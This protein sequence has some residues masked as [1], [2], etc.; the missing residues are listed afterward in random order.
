[1]RLFLIH[2]L[3]APFPV[4]FFQLGGNPDN[5]L[6]MVIASFITQIKANGMASFILQ[7]VKESEHPILS[8]IST[9]TPM[10]SRIMAAVIATGTAIGLHWTYTGSLLAGGTI[11]FSYPGLQAI[12]ATIWQIAQNYLFQHAWYKMVFDPSASPITAAKTSTQP[13][14]AGLQ[15]HG[16]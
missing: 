6:L 10:A 14:Q 7:K 12:L 15:A 16:A 5:P 8:W 9:N 4:S 11:A 13:V 2:I 1:M 3:V